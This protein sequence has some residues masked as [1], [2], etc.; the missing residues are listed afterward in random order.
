MATADSVGNPLLP[1]RDSSE[2]LV[3]SGLA[4]KQAGNDCFKAGEFRQAITEYSAAIDNFEDVQE[5]KSL[6]VGDAPA[7]SSTSPQA[8]GAAP[9][10][11]GG[12]AG[13]SVIGSSDGEVSPS[14]AASSDAEMTTAL[15]PSTAAEGSDME[16]IVR[17]DAEDARRGAPNGSSQENAS[18]GSHQTNG[19]TST[20]S[21]QPMTDQTSNGHQSSQNDSQSSEGGIHAPPDCEMM[22]KVAR[23]LAICYSNRAFCHIK[24]ENFGSAIMDAERACEVDP[25][26][27]KSYYRLGSARYALLKYKDAL[28]AFK[29]LTKLAPQDKDARAKLKECEKAVQQQKFAAA[30][31]SDITA[32]VS[33]TCAKAVE[34]MTIDDSY[35]GPVYPGPENLTPEWI[36]EFLKYM[37]DEKVIHI[38]CAYQIVLDTLKML[39]TGCK[40]VQYIDFPEGSEFTTCGDVHGQYYDLL[41]IWNLNGLPSKENPYLFNGDFV[42]RGSFSVEVILALFVWK[43]CFP[44][45]V[46]LARGNHETR[47]MN[48]LYGFEGETRNKFDVQLYNLFCEVFCYLPLCHVF[49]KEVFIV[50]GG[51]F[52]Q[53]NVTLADLEKEDRIGEPP[54]SGR[55]VEMLWSDPG[56]TLGRMPSKRG[57]G[58]AFGPDVTE[59]FLK[60]N[61]LTMV[62]RSHE[63]KDE[64]YELEHKGRLCTIFSAPNYCDQMRNKGALLRWKCSKDPEWIKGEKEDVIESNRHLR[65]LSY[66]VKSFADVPHPQVRAMR[67]ANPM[68]GSLMGM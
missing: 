26:Y 52:S 35:K 4:S 54:D 7:C 6:F 49:N 3:E 15:D 39:K 55:I 65:K 10:A 61:D 51:L 28:K 63:M 22:K 30:I 60:T 66:Q 38:K 20:A 43:L 1:V 41:N 47:N 50:H 2:S 18:N 12:K 21:D 33:E 25:T 67:F 16:D 23:D 62:V 31:A 40:T 19:T 27:S 17:E 45:H 44:D 58:V 24:L 5:C 29:Q 37:E 64:G 8:T 68:L 9:Q 57:V 48:K 13:I 56:S 46:H 32:P 53:D 59:N 36:K 11:T 42:D 14:T 34:G